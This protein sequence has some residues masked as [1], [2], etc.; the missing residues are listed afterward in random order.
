MSVM[1]MRW[2]RSRTKSKK[3]SIKRDVV[4]VEVV[5]DAPGGGKLE[6][7]VGELG[8]PKKMLKTRLFGNLSKTPMLAN[9][10][11]LLVATTLSLN[12]L[13]SSNG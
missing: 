1:T 8:K 11:L 9:S 4:G 5:V 3:I 13:K 12:G 2:L 10:W 6:R 7:L